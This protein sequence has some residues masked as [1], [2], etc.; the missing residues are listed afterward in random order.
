MN[1]I[2]PEQAKQ[3]FDIESYKKVTGAK[4]FKRTAEEVELGLSPNEALLR[5]L[6]GSDTLK[7]VVKASPSHKGD[8][9]VT[10]RPQVG[11]DSDYFERFQD[12]GP[13]E[14]VLPE[15]WYLWL[16]EKLLAPYNG[17]VGRLLAHILQLGMHTIIPRIQFEKDFQEK[18]NQFLDK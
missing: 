5:R 17:D 16:D 9:S 11:V 6:Q 18:E 13:I 14:V 1:E 2:T 3:I 15:K 4:R 12:S 10:I 8:I 7:N